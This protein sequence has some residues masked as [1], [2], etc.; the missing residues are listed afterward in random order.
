MS[1][2]EDDL[3]IS[4]NNQ[5]ILWQMILDGNISKISSKTDGCEG[6]SADRIH[7]CIDR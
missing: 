6:V 3:E 5:N 1:W 4:A 7:L 2:D